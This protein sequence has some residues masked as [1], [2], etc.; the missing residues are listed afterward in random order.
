MTVPASVRTEHQKF[1]RQCNHFLAV[2]VGSS[3]PDNSVEH[4]L[5][6]LGFA[7][8]A[9]HRGKAHIGDIVERA[10]RLHHHL[11]DGLRGHFALALAFELAHDLGNDL[12]DALGLDR[13]LA[14]GDLDRAQQLVAIERHTAAVALDHNELA[15]LHGARTW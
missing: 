2:A 12:V 6:I 13:T 5:E 9:I 15:Q 14:Q 1:S 7:E 11:A 4:G 10:Q 8:I 3:S